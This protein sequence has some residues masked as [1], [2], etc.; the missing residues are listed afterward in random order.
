MFLCAG[1]GLAVRA[2]LLKAADQDAV[3]R[4]IAAAQP[5]RVQPQPQYPG[6]PGAA[7]SAAVGL[8]PAAGA[9]GSPL[10]PAADL[11]RPG[12]FPTVRGTAANA[13][14]GAPVP[15]PEPL[16]KQSVRLSRFYPRRPAPVFNPPSTLALGAGMPSVV[17][18]AGGATKSRACRASTTSRPVALAFHNYSDTFGV[19]PPDITD[20][21][22]TP[23]LRTGV[24]PF[25]RSSIKPNFINS[26]N[27]TNRGD[28]SNNKKLLDEVPA[29]YR[30]PLLTVSEENEPTQPQTLQYRP[31]RL[32]SG[33]IMQETN[34][35]GFVG[36][37]TR[38]PQQRVAVGGFPR[39][40]FKYAAGRRSQEFGALDEASGLALFHPQADAGTRASSDVIHAAFVDGARSSPLRPNYR[41][42]A[43]C[44]NRTMPFSQ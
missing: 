17:C 44:N 7:G 31:R 24:S 19:L 32:Q 14:V 10:P 20:E 11:P 12:H 34:Y 23:L 42:A 26:S 29:I 39:W 5:H 41:E 30:N 25:C 22:G 33:T 15:V 40:H 4:G 2:G 21:E 28:S 18:A 13:I 43:V 3:D 37:N 35:Q 6:V 36:K 1:G 27:S 16:L 9:G 38:F 8:P